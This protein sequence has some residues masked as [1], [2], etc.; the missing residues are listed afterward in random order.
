MRPWSLTYLMPDSM[1]LRLTDDREL[2]L[3]R[4]HE[5]IDELPPDRWKAHVVDM[6]LQHLQE[7]ITAHRQ[8]NGQHDRYDPFYAQYFG[9]SVIRP[10]MRTHV[11]LR[12]P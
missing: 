8:F 9:T 2:L 6:A 3:E 10:T 12:R 11:E 1:R 4:L 5:Q 7:S